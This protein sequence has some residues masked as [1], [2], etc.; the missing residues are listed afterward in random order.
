[1]RLLQV[2]NV[3]R[4]VGGTAACAWS[5]ARAF[6]DA[7]HHVAFLS[8]ITDDTREA[9]SF[10]SLLHCGRITDAFVRELGVDAVILHNTA[11]ARVEPISSA[12]TLQYV[13]SK[14]LRA[15]A[16][17]TVYCSRWL[18]GQC[19]LEN[20]KI[21]DVLYQCVP[22]PGMPRIRSS[23]L[24][25]L[26]VGRIC[27][28]T[29]AKWPASLVGFYEGLAG[30]HPGVDWEFVGCPRELAGALADACRGRAAFHPAGW[31]ARSHLARWDALLYHHPT[32]TES[33]GRTVAEAMRAG[34][35]PIVDAR[36][37]FREQ[38]TPETGWL[39][40][41][42]EEFSEA[43][44]AISDRQQLEAMSANARAWGDEMF[45]M[46]AFRKRMLAVW[47]G[48]S[49][50]GQEPTQSTPAALKEPGCW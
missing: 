29:T 45:S 43:L 34:C 36:G 30:R 20:A 28:P 33:F 22:C 32:L 39:C 16:D 9:F 25:R 49:M 47:R 12:W 8:S 4:I 44:E 48:S 1:M 38:V 35:V 5:I 13:H 37:G 41:S 31:E 42:L 18:A 14:G 17:R 6:P 27:T 23:R 40:R 15:G 7:A 3:G 21:A 19:G 11:A 2:C 46:G 26:C 10:A 50:S 24:D